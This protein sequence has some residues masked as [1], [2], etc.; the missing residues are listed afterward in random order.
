MGHVCKELPACAS[1]FLLVWRGAK[2]RANLRQNGNFDPNL[3][4]IGQNVLV[5]S[6]LNS[7]TAIPPRP[8]PQPSTMSRAW[9]HA[10]PA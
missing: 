10:R 8:R 7:I 2:F 5:K 3:C 1:S 6:L 9:W 4:E